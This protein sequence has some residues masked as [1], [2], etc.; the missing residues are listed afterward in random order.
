ME[1][2]YGVGVGCL[3]VV[4]V[5]GW[6]YHFLGLLRFASLSFDSSG[7]GGDGDLMLDTEDCI[8]I[9]A[10]VIGASGDMSRSSIQEFNAVIDRYN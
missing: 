3:G 8:G 1:E 4:D 7:G 6:E 10:W 9:L 2:D 5:R